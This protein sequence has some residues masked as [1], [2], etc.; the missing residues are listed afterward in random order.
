MK[1]HFRIALRSI[2]GSLLCLCLPA[3]AIEVGWHDF[4]YLQ[5]GDG[6]KLNHQQEPTSLGLVLLANPTTTN[7]TGSFTETTTFAQHTYNMIKKLSVNSS[8]S[9]DYLAFSGDVNVSFFGK[10]TFNA[11]D[12]TFVYTGIKDFGTT[13]YTPVDF[14]PANKNLVADFQKNLQGAALHSAITRAFGTHYVRG[15][16]L[17][18]MVS[19]VY[20]FHYASA[21]VKQQTIASSSGVYNNDTFS[22]FVNNFFTSTNSTTSMSYQFYSTDPNQ[23]TTNLFASTGIIR[24]YQQFTNFVSR[25]EA[26]ANAM[27]PVHAKITQ[28][29]LDPIQTVPGYLSMLGGYSPPTANPADYDGFLK[30]YAALQAAKQGLATWLLQGN[31]LSW[32][33]AQGRQVMIGQ[34]NQV[35]NYL[36][37]MKSIA[38]SHFTSGA[39]LNVPTDVV[40]FLTGFNQIRFPGISVLKSFKSGS[41]QCIIGRVD[42]GCTNWT[43]PSP[44]FSLSALYYQTNYYS[45]A[46]PSFV[47]IYYNA[48]DFETTQLSNSSGTIN[49]QL[50]SLFNG[51]PGQIWYCLTNSSNPD[52]NGYFL[53]T[54]PFNEAANWSLEI[55]TIDASGNAVPVDEMAFLSTQSAG[56]TIPCQI[57]TPLNQ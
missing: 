28:Y 8:V 57:S 9:L 48:H 46:N 13:V 47:P 25:I 18:A 40:N 36:A 27:N 43:A 31:T 37:A 15:Y 33:N 24:T 56:C 20:T 17:A 42:C 21:S 6:V 55:D 7:N 4:M 16:D 41:D 35:A 32:L 3:P 26:Y 45:T 29:V 22:T 39:P 30:A 38:V 11:N 2:I 53:I 50:K 14:S 19:V 10:Q 12:L 52:V 51:G 5:L 49:T 34:W 1:H 44:F 54:K 23:L